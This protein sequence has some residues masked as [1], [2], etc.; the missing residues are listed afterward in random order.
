MGLLRSSSRKLRAG[1]NIT[2]NVISPG[3][4]DT[5]LS[6]VMRKVVPAERWTPMT[7]V[8]E[9]AEKI[10]K[11]DITGQVFEVSNKKYYQR[12]AVDY[13]DSNAEVLIEDMHRFLAKGVH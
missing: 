5:T 1:E 2:L 7:L 8:L 9:V 4:V 10:L 6:P 3:P 13:A 11:E 12:Q